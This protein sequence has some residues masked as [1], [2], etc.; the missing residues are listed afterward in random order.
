MSDGR[1][2][3]S[4]RRLPDGA[5]DA[6]A[7]GAGEARD[8]GARDVGARAREAGA[9]DVGDGRDGRDAGGRR[10]VAG[11]VLVAFLATT[12]AFAVTVAFSVYAQ[13]RGA[14]DAEE[15]AK[16]FVPVALRLGQLRATQATLATLVDGIPDERD[17]QSTRLLLKTLASVRSATLAETR[18]AL[19]NDLVVAGSDETDGLAAGFSADLDAFEA[20]VAGDDRAVDD[21]F[22]AIERGDAE[23]VNRARVRIGAAEHDADKKLGALA[24]RVS[25]SMEAVSIAA[26]TRER[27]FVLLILA[28]AGFTVAVVVGTSVHV[29]RL[30]RPLGAVT[31]RAR[32]VAQGDRTPKP[33]PPA[34]DE[35][36]ELAVAF[37]KM[38]EAVAAA[39]SR[40]VANERLAA[41]GKMAA[42]VTH[43]IRNP[44]SS[45]SLNIE[46]LEEELQS[47]P[48]PDEAKSLL[49][50]ITREV[51][52]LGNLSEEYLRLARIPSPRLDADDVGALVSEVGKFS[53]PEVE[54]AGCELSVEVE[55]DLPPALFDEAQ[56]RQA[57]LN[58][59]RNAR[60]A[61]P[62]G[63]TVDL[64]AFAEGM[65]V[66]V[67]VEDRGGGIPAEI[68]D[69]VFDPFFSTKG[70]GTGLG[71]AITRRIV[72]AHGAQLTCEPRSG[73][74]TTF[75]IAL[76]LA[77][78]KSLVFP[79]A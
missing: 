31:A 74:G 56:L 34:T 24:L 48:V 28:L 75:R 14:E 73:G 60:E 58:L 18:R 13:R 26:K 66:V 41:I 68:Q 62:Q 22:A 43:E 78:A 9:R 39:Q 12:L 72:E 15:L 27:R 35:I 53:R 69:R 51:E 65:S 5:R 10:G 64:R 2:P 3:P 32:A 17:P 61:M 47:A 44:L 52:R 19:V 50:S 59:L 45:I 71:L 76:P 77:P 55:R 6:G 20:L 46:M 79:K 57:V 49:A 8:V 70:E 33:V 29:S 11:R 16:G 7:R 42:H 38:V 4:E 30:L 40:A 37:E 63:G 25:T 54:R 1:E 67:A 23:A 21:L 36:G